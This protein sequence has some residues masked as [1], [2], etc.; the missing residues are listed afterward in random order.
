MTYCTSICEVADLGFH[1]KSWEE[2]RPTAI[3]DLKTE[4]VEALSI[5]EPLDTKDNIEDDD[6]GWEFRDLV[7]A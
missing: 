3:V 6:S 1:L 5:D 7:P 4:V 2:G